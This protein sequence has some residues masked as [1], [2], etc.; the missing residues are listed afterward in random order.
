M[1]RV[2]RLDG[3]EAVVNTD[4]VLMVENRPDT[5]LTFTTGERM[6]VRESVEDIIAKAAAFRRAVQQG[7]NLVPRQ[8]R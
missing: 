1:I 8:E 4:L 3:S 5:V 6:F 2:T 7:L